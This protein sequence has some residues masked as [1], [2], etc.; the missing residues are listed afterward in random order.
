LAL[1]DAVLHVLRTKCVPAGSGLRVV[2]AAEWV[3]PD[4]ELCDALLCDD[5]LWLEPLDLAEAGAAASAAATSAIDNDKA[6]LVF[7]IVIPQG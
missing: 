7:T 5:E 3:R 1:Q 2:D 4:D 6:R